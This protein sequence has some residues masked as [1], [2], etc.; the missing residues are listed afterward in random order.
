MDYGMI[1]QLEKARRYA[2]E[3]NRIKFNSF[4]VN[5]QG[6][7]SAYV[8]TFEDSEY[9]CTCPGFDKYSICPHV[10]TLEKL[11]KPM[12]HLPPMP[13][14]AGQN[15]VS[16]VEKSHRYAVETDRIQFM[17]FDA[18]F[19]GNNSDHRVT[20]DHGKWDCDSVSFKLRGL[21]SHTIAMERLLKGMLPAEAVQVAQ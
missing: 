8:I 18:V 5:F 17:S 3:P 12:L 2:E 6:D 14:A 7:N 16:D 9:H 4:V 13:Y 15:V 11:F 1:N 19:R 20:F 10:M 21:S